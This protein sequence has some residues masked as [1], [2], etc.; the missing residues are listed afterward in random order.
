MG[1]NPLRKSRKA[2]IVSVRLTVVPQI[3]QISSGSSEGRACAE[4]FGVEED[5]IKGGLASELR[6]LESRRVAGGR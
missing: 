4:K 6:L 5:G 2:F 3:A 1:L